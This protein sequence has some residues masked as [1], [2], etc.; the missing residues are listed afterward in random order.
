MKDMMNNVNILSK[1]LDGLWWRNKAINQNISNANTPNYKRLEV[2]F[3]D[4]LKSALNDTGLKL[5]TTHEKHIGAVK[6]V[7]EIE[8]SIQVDRSYAYRFDGNN[9]DIDVEA[10]NLAKNAIMYN[11]VINQITSEFNKIK[12]VI[13]EGSR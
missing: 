12:S 1:A 13:N 9:V 6:S 10:A 3:E 11:A 8:P 4:R 7:D 2:N 5:K